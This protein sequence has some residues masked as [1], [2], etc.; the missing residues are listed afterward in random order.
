MLAEA[1]RYRYTGQ[2][3]E[4]PQ[5]CLQR[6]LYRIVTQ[7]ISRALFIWPRYCVCQYDLGRRQTSVGSATCVQLL[8]CFW[9][10]PFRGF[11]WGRKPSRLF[12][13]AHDCWLLWALPQIPISHSFPCA[14]PFIP[15]QITIVT[16]MQ[17]RCWKSVLFL[18]VLKVSCNSK[19]LPLTF[20]QLLLYLCSI[21]ICCGH[22]ETSFGWMEQ[23]VCLGPYDFV[24]LKWYEY[25]KSPASS[26][27]LS[28]FKGKKKLPW[29]TKIN[30]VT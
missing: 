29:N 10:T 1:P 19:L 17:C 2:G 4:W 25:S 3:V 9:C 20:H 27:L 28:N 7:A 18:V 15:I 16:V 14:S 21:W 6:A 30:E 11:I 8:T 22:W 24:C 5:G 23:R 13:I 26:L 12:A